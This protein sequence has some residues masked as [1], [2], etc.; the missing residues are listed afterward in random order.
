MFLKSIKHVHKLSPS[1]RE[2]ERESEHMWGLKLL[3]FS[4]KKCKGKKCYQIEKE[5]SERLLFKFSI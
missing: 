3:F 5:N 2:R 4:W 1:G